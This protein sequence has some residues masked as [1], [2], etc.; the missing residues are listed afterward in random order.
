MFQ[1]YIVI[2]YFRRL[3]LIPSVT[4]APPA[5]GSTVGEILCGKLPGLSA[6]Q[7]RLCQLYGDHITP[8]A[9]G[10]RQ[11]VKEC[12]HQFRHRRWNCT[13]VEDNTV[14]GPVTRICKST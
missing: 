5:E 7:V 3:G 10:A 11:A 14:F 13:T 2:L 4:S 9:H 6:G 1:V 12:Q 8:V